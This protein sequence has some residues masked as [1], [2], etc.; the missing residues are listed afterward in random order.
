MPMLIF[1]ESVM[2]CRV[3]SGATKKLSTT[4]GGVPKVHSEYWIIMI[5]AAHM[6]NIATKSRFIW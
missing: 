6:R 5:C 4:D 2:Q 1:L 3:V